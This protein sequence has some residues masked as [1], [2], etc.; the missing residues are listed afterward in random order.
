EEP[1]GAGYAEDEHHRADGEHPAK[2]A[3]QQP[4]ARS[5]RRA[6]NASP[7]SGPKLPLWRNWLTLQIVRCGRREEVWSPRF[8]VKLRPI[9]KENPQFGAAAPV[10]A[11]IRLAKNVCTACT[12]E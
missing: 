6:R 7:A 8:V 12:I 1:G 5:S 3:Q 10:L 11:A 9:L 4:H 2:E